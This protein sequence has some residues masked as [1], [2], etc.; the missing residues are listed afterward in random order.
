M[1]IEPA[2]YQLR[3][4]DLPG[5]PTVAHHSAYTNAVAHVQDLHKQFYD[6]LQANA[7][8]GGSCWQHLVIL[9]SADSGLVPCYWSTTNGLRPRHTHQGTGTAR[10]QQT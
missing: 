4:L 8:G 2:A 3:H 5:Q 9:E 1:T 6:Q 7:E 10:W